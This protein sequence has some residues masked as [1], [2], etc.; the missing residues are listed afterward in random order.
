MAAKPIFYLFM[1]APEEIPV[2]YMKSNDFRTVFASGIIGGVTAQGKI[3]MNIYLDRPPI[4]VRSVLKPAEE[5]KP[6]IKISVKEEPVES[7]AGIIREIQCGVLMDFETAL[8]LRTWL[9]E[10]IEFIQSNLN[11]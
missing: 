5:V 9:D 2:H 6:G 1:E 3:S 10:K 11:R 8:S 4:P 7:K